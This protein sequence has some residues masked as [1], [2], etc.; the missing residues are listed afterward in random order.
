MHSIVNAPKQ[1]LLS[2]IA[3]IILIQI[4][5]L[6]YIGHPWICTCGYIEL[7]HGEVFS[8]GNS[9]H[10]TDWYT[11]S[12]IIHGFIFYV[13]LWAVFPKSPILLR[14]LLAVGIETAWEIF[15]NSEFIMNR[16]RQ[17][18]LA[19]DYYGDSIINSVSDTASMVLGFLLARKLPVWS[20]VLTAIVF[21]V[22]TGYMIHDNLTLNII[23]L[24]H[25]FEFISVW[26]TGV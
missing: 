24:I 14:L 16:Y 26:Q 2:V 5:A 11:Y 8:S 1:A 3:V 21:E 12:H 20:I 19:L 4:G 9:Q 23:T 17:T 18:A 10:I 13:L 15:E 25:P 7:W 6:F 22:F